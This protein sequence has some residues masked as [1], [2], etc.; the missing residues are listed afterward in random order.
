M[1]YS[2]RVSSERRRTACEM[3]VILMNLFNM[4]NLNFSELK[5]AII[6]SVV[7]PLTNVVKEAISKLANGIDI[8]VVG[9]GIKTG[10]SILVDNPRE[11]GTDRIV[12][13]CAGYHLYGGPLIIVDF[14]T[15]TTFDVVSEKGEYLGGAISPG[16][17]ISMEALFRETAQLPR[18]DFKKPT[19]V[20][21]K[22]TVESM[23]SG[24]F[25]GYVALVDGMI[26]RMIGEIGKAK[27]IATGGY[28]NLISSSS[29]Y[30]EIVEPNL[31]L[32]GL[33]IIYDKNR[34]KNI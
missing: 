4:E 9:P 7:P 11:V 30:I 29:K 2:W 19:R 8:I 27:V 34:K 24:I 31:T 20:I 3:S 18:V 14:G 28:A 21:G 13:A 15:A 22:N 23:H 17:G 10:I 32:I 25:F 12:N 1:V 26:E 16:I 5:G 33:K 6:S